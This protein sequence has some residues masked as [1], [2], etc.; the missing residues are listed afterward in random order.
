MSV[1]ALTSFDPR[2][3]F[4]LRS[5][6]DGGLSRLDTRI[7]A[8]ALSNDLSGRLSITTTEGDRV[9]LSADLQ[10][11]FR[12]VHYG[13]RVE[14]ERAA[15]GIEATDERYTLDGGFGV[16]FDGKINEEERQ[17]I[18]K[19]FDKVSNIFRN[20]FQGQ[21]EEALTHTANLAE[22]FA[23]SSSLASL[24]LSVDVERSITVL[25]AQVASEVTGQLGSLTDTS[26]GR[27]T[28]SSPLGI[29][30]EVQVTSL[31]EQILDALEEVTVES[32]KFEKYLPTLFEKLREDL[33]KTLKDDSEKKPDDQDHAADQTPEK[34]PAPTAHSSL[35]VAYRTASYSSLSLSI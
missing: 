18:E 23:G 13:S 22:R 6:S 20:F 1:Q 21:D 31:I 11:D 12:A 35:L 32:R 9:T 24:D 17:D 14:V 16:T 28:N 2:Q 15:M 8:V 29:P 34:V 5:T 19:L 3:F 4:N 30:Q 27:P 25:A 33:A 7:S 10:S 26:S